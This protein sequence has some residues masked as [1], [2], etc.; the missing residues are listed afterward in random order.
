MAV[1]INPTSVKVSVKVSRISVNA[2]PRREPV[3]Q[4]RP[5]ASLHHRTLGGVQ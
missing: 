3:I 4:C 1:K 2:L 5:Y